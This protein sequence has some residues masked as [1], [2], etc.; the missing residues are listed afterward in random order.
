MRRTDVVLLLEVWMVLMMGV[1]VVLAANPPSPK[2]ELNG[3]ISKM[4]S[5]CLIGLKGLKCGGGIPMSVQNAQLRGANAIV[6]ESVII[7]GV[8]YSRVDHT[9]KP[10]ILKSPTAKKVPVTSTKLLN[11]MRN[12]NEFFE[13]VY[14]ADGKPIYNGLYS[15]NSGAEN[16]YQN[17]FKGDMVVMDAQQQ[18]ITHQVETNTIQVTEDF[19]RIIDI[20]PNAMDRDL[21]NLVI[22]SFGDSILTSVN[23]GGVVDMVVSVRSCFSDANMKSYLDIQLQLSVDN[24]TDTSSLPTGYIRY[25]KVAQLD[26]VG[27][28]P[29]IFNV[30]ERVKTFEQNPVPVKFLSIPIWRAFP[31][32]PK[33]EN[34]KTVYNEYVNQK[35]KE[36][37]GL[38][39]Q[40]EDKRLQ[41]AQTVYLFRD[42]PY[43]LIVDH[44]QRMELA[45]GA[46][47]LSNESIKL[48]F[49]PNFPYDEPT[50][51]FG[52]RPYVHRNNDGSFFFDFLKGI[53]DNYEIEK[54]KYPELANRPQTPAQH[55]S[56]T[57]KGECVK[58]K[59]PYTAQTRYSSFYL[60][61][62][63]GCMPF[64]SNTGKELTC[65]CPFVK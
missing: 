59:F 44:G 6:D 22:T 63:S 42:N 14:P 56:P 10:Q 27:G 4:E 24:N 28:N 37:S 12:A 20:L 62:C 64:I 21:Y 18:Y 34:M 47:G 51:I 31:A 49:Q 7:A 58:L 19:Q 40:L 9:I 50:I 29:Q 11:V 23:Y 35:G 1:V 61:A 53:C 5:K 41:E 32:G 43:G 57:G 60:W 55:I 39:T 16:I 38:F 17:Y 52:L 33:Q 48:V 46:S 45:P 8:G 13:L 54:C 26:I 30:K 36:I 2:I 3:Q 65:N 15:H 25:N